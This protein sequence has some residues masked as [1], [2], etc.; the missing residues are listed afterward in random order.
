L[1]I[2]EAPLAYK[3]LH[4]ILDVIGDTVEVVDVMKPIYHFK[5]SEERPFGT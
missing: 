3:S 4:D 2:V 5:A 1:T